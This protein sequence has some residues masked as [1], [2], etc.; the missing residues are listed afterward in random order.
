M[1]CSVQINKESLVIDYIYIF[2]NGSKTEGY[3]ICRKS[4]SVCMSYV[5]E[6]TLFRTCSVVQRLLQP[7][8]APL[9]FV[10]AVKDSGLV[11]GDCLSKAEEPD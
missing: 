10:L 7:A 3:S 11:V 2:L 9:N 1:Q 8:S 4:H 5:A 6:L